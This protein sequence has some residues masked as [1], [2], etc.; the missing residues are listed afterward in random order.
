[1]NSLLNFKF[2]PMKAVIIDDEPLAR[3]LLREYLK[4]FPQIDICAEAGDGFQGYKSIVEKQ[5]DLIFLDVQMPKING[6]EMLELLSNPPAI[7]FTTAYDEY[8]IKAFEK[9]AIDYLLKPFSKERFAKAIQKL[10]DQS[11][12]KTT[13]DKALLSLEDTRPLHQGENK[14]IVVQDGGKI[15][16]IPVEDVEYL[17]AYG[18]YV[19]I[20]SKGKTLLKKKT[21][22]Y[23]EDVLD[24]KTFLRIHRSFIININELAKIESFEKNSYVAITRLGNR[25]SISRSV[26]PELRKILGI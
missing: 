8:A 2:H 9:N 11:F 12:N 22:S 6:F 18:D 15:T 23:Y 4:E 19:K 5:P 21:L 20:H 16:I 14:R 3:Q 13:S 17:E 25:L 7:I 24:S 26:Y 1:M 10:S